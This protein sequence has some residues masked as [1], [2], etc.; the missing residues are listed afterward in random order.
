MG[1]VRPLVSSDLA[2]L[3]DLIERDPVRNCFVAQRV[4]LAGVDPWRLGGD[5][6]GYVVDGAVESAVYVGA[7]L[8]PISTTAEL[9]A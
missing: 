8:V 1:V 3:E 5:M 9:F 2:S 7:N 4:A 6:W